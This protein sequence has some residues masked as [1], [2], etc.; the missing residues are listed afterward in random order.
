MPVGPV[1]FFIV[2]LPAPPNESIFIPPVTLVKVMLV[3]SVKLTTESSVPD[4]DVSFKGIFV[5]SLSPALKS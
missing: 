3:P 2:F 1:W 5:P 4:P